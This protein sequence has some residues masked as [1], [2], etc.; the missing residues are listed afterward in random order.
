MNTSVTPVTTGW[1][2][3]KIDLNCFSE[4]VRQS[5]SGMPSERPSASETAGS[6]AGD[7]VRTPP[8]APETTSAPRCAQDWAP[9]GGGGGARPPQRCP[10][11]RC[12]ALSAGGG[13]AGGRP[14]RRRPDAGARVHP[15]PRATRR[16]GGPGGGRRRSM[17]TFRAGGSRKVCAP[18]GAR[19]GRAERPR[20][21]LRGLRARHGC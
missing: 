14:P 11:R 19:G 16:A 18:A 9:N 6:G 15:V 4:G 12:S 10:R 17:R 20:A 3:V 13:G 1:G 5:R 8:A 21:R 2:R 7:A